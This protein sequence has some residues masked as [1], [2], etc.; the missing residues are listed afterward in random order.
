VEEEESMPFIG[1]NCPK[2][3]HS[4]EQKA[5]LA[6]RLVQALIRQEIDPLTEIGTAATGFFF[7]ELEIE[8]CFPGGVPPSEHPDKVF[9]I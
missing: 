1:V 3:A 6:P 5:T 7:N 2:G 4:S 9:W 8:N